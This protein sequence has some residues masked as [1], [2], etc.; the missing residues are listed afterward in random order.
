VIAVAARPTHL[1]PGSAVPAWVER[2][3]SACF[4]SVWGALDEGDHLWLL[5]GIGFA[6]WKVIGPA[7]EAELVRIAIEPASR[8]TGLGHELLNACLASLTRMGVQVLHLEVRVSNQAAR[9]LYEKDGWVYQGVRKGY[10]R[11]GEDA[12]LYRRDLP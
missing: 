3:D 2:L 8:R 1:G 6:R 11:D 5:P 12:A 10:Y 7:Q 4:G 9:A